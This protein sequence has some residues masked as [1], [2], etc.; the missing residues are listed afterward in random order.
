MNNVLADLNMPLRF[1]YTNEFELLKDQIET[2]IYTH[3]AAIIPLPFYYSENVRIGNE[4]PGYSYMFDN[5]ITNDGVIL[6]EGKY[7]VRFFIFCKGK[8]HRSTADA[9]VVGVNTE[10][11]NSDQSNKS[12]NIPNRSE[13]QKTK[14]NI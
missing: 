10:S 5:N 12:P 2:P 7:S 3:N 4:N 1:A 11:S 8:L 13:I 9:L 6:E 14:S